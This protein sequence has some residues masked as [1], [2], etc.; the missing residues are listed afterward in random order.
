MFVSFWQYCAGPDVITVQFLVQPVWPDTKVYSGDVLNGLIC[1]QKATERGGGWNFR[2]NSN[3][4]VKL[5]HS[6]RGVSLHE[7]EKDRGVDIFSHCR[8]Y[9]PYNVYCTDTTYLAFILHIHQLSFT[10]WWHQE[11]IAVWV[12]LF[13][14]FLQ[15][16]LQN[17]PYSCQ[18]HLVLGALHSIPA[19][20]VHSVYK[21]LFILAPTLTNLILICNKICLCYPCIFKDVPNIYAF[22]TQ[23]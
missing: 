12:R 5:C 16:K 11:T 9:K 21:H 4:V 18:V 1:Q 14:I 17:K 22:S 3:A 2:Q 10:E 7:E 19:V 15:V 20:Y 8:L 23:F 6:P 13:I